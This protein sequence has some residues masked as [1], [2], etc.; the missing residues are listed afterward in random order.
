M[1]SQSSME[2][3]STTEKTNGHLVVRSVF[4]FYSSRSHDDGIV[5]MAGSDIRKNSGSAS[6]TI[7]LSSNFSIKS[8][9]E[10]RINPR[11]YMGV[12]VD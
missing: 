4:V 8:M 9:H 1:Q 6:H 3:T 11:K 12:R 2:S 7:S 5:T 10:F